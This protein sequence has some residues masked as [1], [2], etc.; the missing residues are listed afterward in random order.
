[1]QA[2]SKWQR[3]QARQNQNTAG[4]KR[5]G[6]T[7]K[8]A[9]RTGSSPLPALLAGAAFAALAVGGVLFVRHQQKHKAD[10]AGASLTCSSL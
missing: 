1:M 2:R 3:P 6:P 10:D 7:G 9:E 5:C 4:K 8:E